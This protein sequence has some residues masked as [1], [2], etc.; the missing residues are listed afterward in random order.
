MI[1]VKRLSQGKGRRVCKG[2]RNGE[3]IFTH[4]VGPTLV[5]TGFLSLA[6]RSAHKYNEGQEDTSVW[7]CGCPDPGG[8]REG[9]WVERAPLLQ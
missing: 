9:S 2:V 4:N 6:T 7:G 8:E 5:R 1:A 3:A